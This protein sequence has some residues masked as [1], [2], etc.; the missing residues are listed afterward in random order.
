MSQPDWAPR[1]P[2]G[3]ALSSIPVMSLLYFNFIRPDE[4][5]AERALAYQAA[6]DMAEY[7][8]AHG[9][10]QVVLSEHHGTEAWRVPTP[11]PRQPVRVTPGARARPPVS[12]AR[13]HGS[14]PR[15]A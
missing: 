3:D 1:I 12:P 2:G 5:P 9:F 7:A 4:E 13:G 6:L 14:S 15:H 8:D 11:P 10:S